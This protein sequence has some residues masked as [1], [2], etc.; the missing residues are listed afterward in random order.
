M[1]ELN[2]YSHHSFIVVIATF[3]YMLGVL[4]DLDKRGQS[5]IGSSRKTMNSRLDLDGGKD[6]VYSDII[7]A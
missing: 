2:C 4:A 1:K 3:L 6:P 7:S 5:R